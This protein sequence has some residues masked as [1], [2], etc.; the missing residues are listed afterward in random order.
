MWLMACFPIP[1]LTNGILEH[2][3]PGTSPYFGILMHMEKK[4]RILVVD[5]QKIE[6][7][8]ISEFL[9]TMSYEV[10]MAHDGLEALAKLALD[11][12]LIL[13]DGAMPKMDGFELTRR[14]RDNEEWADKPIIMVTALG[15]REARLK[16]LEAGVDD[17]I[18]KPVCSTELKVRTSLL[19]ELHKKRLQ[20][21]RQKE[22]LE[23]KVAQKTKALKKALDEMVEAKRAAQ[24]AHLETVRCLALAA[25]YKDSTTAHHI[26]RV[27]M[28]CTLIGVA[29]KLSQEE[30]DTLRVSA[31]LHDVGKLT[32]SDSL[33]DNS[34]RL[35]DEQWQ[36]VQQHT[37]KGAELL[38]DSGSPYLRAAAEICKFHHEKWD[39]SGYP[40]G[41]C[42]EEIPLFARIVALADVFDA[43]TSG[44]SEEVLE[45]GAAFDY[46]KE[47]SGKSFEPRLV[48]LFCQ[49]EN[50]IRE[51]QAK[52]PSEPKTQES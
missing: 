44:I 31:T 28:Y 27:C 18:E 40:E 9:K 46:L 42:G 5:D 36:K 3:A 48:E 1:A 32:I 39:G 23:E 8:V 6:A 30:L 33:L 38:E 29:L 20:E 13:V 25:E 41:L 49:E 16:A 43:L 35:S 17:F 37:V 14:L 52:W 45:N 4:H 24:A 22:L 2:I 50:R 15:N 10:E 26:E 19:L 11:F 34:T 51:I 12:S 7:E 21:R 47:E